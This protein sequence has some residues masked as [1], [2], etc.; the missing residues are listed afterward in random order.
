MTTQCPYAKNTLCAYLEIEDAKV[1]C[2][3]CPY[4]TKTPHHTPGT[5]LHEKVIKVIKLNII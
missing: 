4:F 1:N 5:P 2:S 3:T